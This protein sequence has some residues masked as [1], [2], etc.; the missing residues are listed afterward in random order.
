MA[1]SDKNTPSASS[2]PRWS[3]HPRMGQAEA[4]NPELHPGLPQ[5]WQGP[6][7][8]GHSSLPS[9]IHAGLVFIPF[10]LS[11]GFRVARI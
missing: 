5:G 1:G 11:L 2:P 6:K 8:L 9:Q 4:R 3:Y 7:L 10:L